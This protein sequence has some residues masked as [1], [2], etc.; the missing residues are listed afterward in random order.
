[1]LLNSFVI[2]RSMCCDIIVL[3]SCPEPLLQIPLLLLTL[4]LSKVFLYFQL[5]FLWFAFFFLAKDGVLMKA[6]DL[7]TKYFR[8]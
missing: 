6:D 8:D 1:M 3:T 2:I 7:M 4:L 5:Y